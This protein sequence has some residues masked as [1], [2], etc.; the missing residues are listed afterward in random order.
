MATDYEG[1]ARAVLATPQGGRII[2]GLEKIN[3]ISRTETGRQ[4]F[5][6]LA[7]TGA[8]EVRAAARAALNDPKEPAR[9]LI[10][11]LLSTKEGANLA[12][13]IIELMG[14]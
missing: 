4:L 1:I 13:K 3:S 11:T 8:D 6:I 12:A 14:V 5:E 7:G 10:S 9:A 2:K